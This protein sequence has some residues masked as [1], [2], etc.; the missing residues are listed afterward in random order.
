MQN[1]SLYVKLL[2][3][4]DWSHWILAFVVGSSLRLVY[5]VQVDMPDVPQLVSKVME[6][7]RTD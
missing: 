6:L 2:L 1:K 5:D 7:K 4:A 3:K